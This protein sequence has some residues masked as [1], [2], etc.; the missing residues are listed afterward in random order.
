M[1]FLVML[2]MLIATTFDF[3]VAENWLPG[4]AR[5]LVEVIGAIVLLYV[6]AAGVGDRFRFVR[7]AYWIAFGAFLLTMACGVVANHV[8]PG[9]LFAGLRS[10]LRGMPLFF[11]AAVVKFTDRQIKA[12]LWL[13]LGISIVQLP[14]AVH[15]RIATLAY[16]G[17]TGDLTFGT[18]MNSSTLS[19]FLICGIAIVMGLYLRKLLAM[20][21]AA[22]LSL[23]LL[24]P[25]T[26]NETKGTLL[27]LP[28]ALGTTFMLDAKPGTRLKNVL[29]VGTLLG[30]FGAI[31]I[32]IYD[33]LIVVRPHAMTVGEFFTNPE[34]VEEYLST[35]GADV[36]ASKTMGRLD[37][38]VVPLRVLARDPAQLVFGLGV[39]N[40]SHSSLGVR[41]TGRYNYILE[42]FL[43]TTFAVVVS[44]LGLLGICLLLWVHWLILSDCRVM[45][46]SEDRLMSS[47]ALGWA[48]VTMVMVLSLPYKNL[49]PYSSLTFLF[50]YFS[51]L[52]AA[53]R[54]RLA[55]APGLDWRTKSRR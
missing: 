33:A 47:I 41:F 55:Y 18:L 45:A 5:Y 25:T 46:R 52:I 37:S 7:P 31:F 10:F 14:L 1:Q 43:I 26:I 48:G 16:G 40:A 2:M 34:R 17:I 53:G 51:G 28:L 39:G 44:E 11:L 27:L 38:I 35:P 20:K 21:I 50:W 24:I 22:M 30:V 4:A 13:L 3:F 19:I 29:L 15:Q 32:P 8:E 36:G 6:V 23:L 54:M 9:P 42:P 49:I 12:Q